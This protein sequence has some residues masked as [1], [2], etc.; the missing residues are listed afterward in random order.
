MPDASKF[1]PLKVGV[2]AVA[3]PKCEAP[4]GLSAREPG[5][6]EDCA[7][8]GGT[9]VR[10]FGTPGVGPCPVCVRPMP[11]VPD[12]RN[13]W[14]RERFEAPPTAEFLEELTYRAR[15]YGWNGD[16]SEIQRFMMELFADA[17]TAEPSM[18]AFD[19]IEHRE[20][21]LAN[22]KARALDAPTEATPPS[23]DFLAACRR[24]A[25]I[26]AQGHHHTCDC[27]SCSENR[28]ATVIE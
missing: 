28:G 27:R 19:W 7:G 5:S 13:V 17:G 1:D 6:A 12:K 4:P 2:Y 24:A 11:D 15:K 26:D 18:E 16:Y 3:C 23:S 8:C 25:A 21:E 10:G 14:I 22:E 9:K 20:Q